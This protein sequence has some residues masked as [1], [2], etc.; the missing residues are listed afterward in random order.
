MAYPVYIVDIP[1][2][3]TMIVVDAGYFPAYLVVS[4]RNGIGVFGVSGMR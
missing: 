1:N 3:Q 2:I 4:D